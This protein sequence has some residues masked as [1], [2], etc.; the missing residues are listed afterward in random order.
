MS[1]IC[2]VYAN[3]FYKEYHL[4]KVDDADFSLTL[5]G[6]EFGFSGGDLSL[7]LE[8][9][10]GAWK[11]K[12]SSR[13]SV[14]LQEKHFEG[15][16]LLPGTHLEV[17]R[18]KRDRAALLV[19][20]AQ[21]SLRAFQKYKVVGNRITIGKNEE[22]DIC[23]PGQKVLSAYH[24]ELEFR[25]GETVLKDL[26]T[27]GTYCGYQRIQ[28]EY[29][30]SFGEV[31]NLFGLTVIYLG[32][33]LAIG[34]LDG[35]IKINPAKMREV[36]RDE[37]ITPTPS[38]SVTTQEE[39]VHISP[40]SI[41]KRY[42][43]EETIDPAPAKKEEDK[44]PAWMSILPSFTMVIPMLLGFLLMSGGMMYGL[45][46]SVSSAAIGGA[47]S[48]INYRH[49]KEEQLETEKKRQEKYES[50]LVSCTDRIR[51]KFEFNR[52]SL[53]TMYPEAAV[54]AGYRADSAELWARKPRHKDFLFLRMGLGDRP[55]EVKINV[56][57]RAF[58]MMEDELSERPEKIQQSYATMR[59]VPVGLQLRDHNVVGVL[60]GGDTAAAMQ[61]IRVL[62]TQLTA[63]HS[64]TDVKLAA[65]FSENSD[66][67]PMWEYLRWFPHVWNED[68]SVRYLA[69][70]PIGRNDI[71][72]LLA[73]L[74][75]GRKEQQEHFSAT[76]E[77]LYLPWYVLFVENPKL[78]EE[79][80][81][82]KYLYEDGAALGV[83][84]VI[85]SDTYENLPSACDY[86]IEATPQFCGFYT[87]GTEDEE[88]HAVQ[89][90]S[91]SA[92]QTERMARRM[93]AMR[94][95]QEESGSDVPNS[96]TFFEMLEAER[97]E[98]LSVLEHWRKNRTYETM[99][100]LIGK[101]MGN[102]PC[103]LD[104]NEK[105]HGPHGL[106]AGTTGSGKSETLQT[107]ML[108][109]A[110]NYSPL[111]VGF[112]VIDFKGGGMANLFSGLPHMM[113]QISNL[114]GNQVRRAMVSIKSE[115]KRRERIFG[116]YGVKNIDEY[117]KLVK[118]KEATLPI[119]HLLII[120]DEFAELKREEPEFMNELIS[121][122]QIGRSLGV[123]L[124]LAT[125]KPAGTVD[126]KIW[127]N[128]R[129]KLCLRVAD[130]QDSNDMLHKPDAAYLTRAGRGYLQVGNDE[131]YELFQ[132]GWSGAVYDESGEP[133][134]G[135]AA[136]LD[137]QGREAVSGSR[138]KGQRRQKKQQRWILSVVRAVLAAAGEKNIAELGAA[139]ISEL[140]LKTIAQLQQM[141]LRYSEN[142]SNLHRLEQLIQ[143]WKDDFDS[144]EEIA[145][146]LVR[147][148]AAL[149]EPLPE[150]Q[151]R[152]QLDAVVE[153]L[154]KLAAENGFENEQRLWMPLLPE[155]LTLRE[156]DPEG[157]NFFSNG[158]WRTH[159]DNFHLS[160]LIGMVDDPENQMQYPLSVDL[161]E[162]GH[163]IVAGGVTSGKSTF[164][165]SYLFSLISTYSP[166]EL[167]IYAVDYSSQMLLS[168]QGAAHT[169]GVVAEGEEERLKKLFTMMESTLNTR[170]KLLRGGS[171]RQ[172][173]KQHPGALPAIVLAIDGYASFQEKT[174]GEFESILLELSRSAEN[175][176][177]YL[178][179][180]CGGIGGGDL[181]N[182]I[183]ANMRQSICL[184]L[185]DK[186]RYADFLHTTHFD[187]LPEENRKGRGLA[188]VN[189]SVLEFQTALVCEAT[190]DYMRSEKIEQLCAEMTAAWHGDS[191]Q[192]IPEIP[193][194]P[195]WNTFC[196]LPAYREAI[197]NG[198]LPIGYLQRTAEVYS[199][200]PKSY[201]CNLILGQE[202][203]G[204]SVCLLN[205]L[206]AAESL[207][208]KRV[209]IDLQ[210][211]EARVAAMS[212]VELVTTPE[213]MVEYTRELIELTN[214]RGAL[215]N[216]M[217]K[218]GA[219]EEE[220][221][222][223]IAEQFAP[224]WYFI[225][226][227][228]S[229]LDFI[230]T[231]VEGVGKLSPWFENI[232]AKGE[233]LNVHFTAV[234]SVSQLPA[235]MDK[236]AYNTLIQ[237]RKGIL[238]GGELANQNIFSC[239]T[240]PFSE[241]SKRLKPGIAY[242]ADPETEQE[243]EQVILPNRKDGVSMT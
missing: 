152:T 184:D 23:Y 5:K 164:L 123:H 224:V 163:L 45:V 132:S 32:E 43:K 39:T 113:G 58:S 107:Y 196:R 193:E 100:A 162:K 190:G 115:N 169:G 48:V 101:K 136:I 146:Y 65:V 92:G 29:R 230:Y 37:L 30:L 226:D 114:S 147:T 44:K 119:P 156:L 225:A 129:F 148:F 180:S 171:F 217:R 238:L 111:D 121:V 31:I 80:S 50:Y 103:W 36:E 157:E 91:I 175:Y 235:M 96:V 88:Y 161:A 219:E 159:G 211:S 137:L 26:S 90:D 179:I 27:N 14:K 42:S 102:Q 24:A 40:R 186:Y 139:E 75:R 125:Q 54:C 218:A 7:Q 116:E 194:K 81:V 109:L 18:G 59:D 56:P 57:K 231:K 120:I 177:I 98:E 187:V 97:L 38:A 76:K 25:G 216:Q 110:V 220:I 8:A 22:N 165:Q 188:L 117:T 172:Y 12:K 106:V 229:F 206:S 67:A 53:L 34:C 68:R 118:N 49:A 242:V 66:T 130:K 95:N 78:L 9:V 85:L 176:G 170:K 141:G 166:S 144:E 191:A 151:E 153:Y 182:K 104:I 173:L 1:L 195:E 174:E 236:A 209:V 87:L 221:R 203:S 131:I 208:G 71:L 215:R 33:F 124:I 183:A 185:G 212:G 73:Q 89:F 160:G 223:K 112:F 86:V 227:L 158:E 243:L 122:S 47:W 52:A 200:D 77:K 55:F 240:I 189:G 222:E 149:G 10:N 60:T 69:N 74:L 138:L 108:S 41:P 3:S 62:V 234:A 168:L 198:L 232:F 72:H 51:E 13:Y 213:Q 201:Y 199:I 143:L 192:P 63:N 94:V 181:Q 214:E 207:G 15:E 145:D 79:Q 4:P 46:I 99:R 228:K 239:Q 135:S 204:K 126:E 154:G 205:L 128:T 93:N 16:V 241:R 237:A 105:Y 61:L 155:K 133:E 17:R 11:I 28:G 142:A 134:Q 150:P 167:N 20:R 84:T 21:D 70:D 82:A 140:A 197:Q 6:K 210:S 127:S 35:E 83:T 233:L 64:Y 19:W 202:R 2:A 178:L